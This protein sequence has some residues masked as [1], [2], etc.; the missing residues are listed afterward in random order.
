[1][2]LLRKSAQYLTYGL[3]VIAFASGSIVAWFWHKNEHTL[4]S[5]QNIIFVIIIPVLS[6]IGAWLAK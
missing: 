4:E 5:L 6:F 1:M 3:I 2:N